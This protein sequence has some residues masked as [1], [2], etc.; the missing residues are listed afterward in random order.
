[1]PNHFPEQISPY[2]WATNHTSIERSL[3]VS[4]FERAQSMLMDQQGEVKVELQF[5]VDEPNTA[6]LSG[7]LTATVNLQCQRCMEAVPTSIKSQFKIG[8]V[9]SE[10]EGERLSGEYDPLVA[11]E[12]DFSLLELIEDELILAIPI[13]TSHPKEACDAAHFLQDS[14]IIKE[15]RENPFQ[16]LEQLKKQ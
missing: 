10:E 6:F 7:E 3:P 2:Q 11:D 12:R 5:G 16:V 14:T 9:H 4:R 15:K 1:M 8:L 13:V